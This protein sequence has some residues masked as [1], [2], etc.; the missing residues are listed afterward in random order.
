MN[1]LKTNTPLI[2]IIKATGNPEPFSKKKLY[3]SIQHTGLSPKA[4]QKITEKVASEVDEGFKTRDIYRKAL[5]LV[6]ENSH[7]AAIHYSLKRALFDLGPTGHNFETYVSKYFHA[8]GFETKTCQTVQGKLVPHEVDVIGSKN[9]QK[10]FV[11]CKFHNHQGIKNDIKI[12][13]YVKARWDDLREGPEGKNLKKFYLAS[14]TSFSLDAK[15]YANGTGLNLLGVNAPDDISFL[16][17]I[18]KM[19]L[20]PITSLRQVNRFTKNYLLSNG[21]ILAQDVLNQRQLLFQMGM[22]DR[23]VKTLFDEINSLIH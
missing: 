13:L 16:D 1:K 10:I 5:S 7:V 19:K 23:N 20:Y 14:N 11:E 22:T 3:T 6:R 4:C 21:I 17:E 15:I 8:L 12:A 2:H 9:N 18:K